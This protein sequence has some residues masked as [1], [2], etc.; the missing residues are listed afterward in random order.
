MR[1]KAALAEGWLAGLQFTVGLYVL[2]G[3]ETD[4]TALVD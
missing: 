3:C 1:G 2:E 4:D